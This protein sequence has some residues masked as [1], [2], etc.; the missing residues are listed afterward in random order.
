MTEK[1]THTV[2]TESM[3]H[4]GFDSI[5]RDQ[6]NERETLKEKEQLSFD[7]LNFWGW[8]GQ[9]LGSHSYVSV[10][11]A[12]HLA[13]S[14]RSALF[15]RTWDEPM[16]HSGCRKCNQGACWVL[17]VSLLY[18]VGTLPTVW[19]VA[20]QNLKLVHPCFQV[21]LHSDHWGSHRSKEENRSREQNS[22]SWSVTE[23]RFRKS[24]NYKYCPYLKVLTVCLLNSPR[25]LNWPEFP[26]WRYLFHK[27][28]LQL[29]CTIYFFF[30]K[31]H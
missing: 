23:S 5:I 13:T 19:H 29:E 11:F 8:S 30:T 12:V 22:G 2:L 21:Q 16:C 27:G 26:Q 28:R 20:G 7:A 18:L 9:W 24:E 17:S 6:L 4:R 25:P 15:N 31:T 14:G 1:V 3:K 10:H